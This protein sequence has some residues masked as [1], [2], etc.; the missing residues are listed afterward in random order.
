M[1]DTGNEN[2]KQCIYP[3]SSGFEMSNIWRRGPRMDNQAI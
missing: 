1:S 3:K 2:R